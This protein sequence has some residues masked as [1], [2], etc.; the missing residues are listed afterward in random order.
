MMLSSGFAQ[1]S[2]NPTVEQIADHI[3]RINIGTANTG[4]IVGEKYDLL[5]C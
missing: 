4:F 5:I 1:Q 3:Y 2:S